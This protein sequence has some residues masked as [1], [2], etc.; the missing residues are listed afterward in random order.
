MKRLS[1]FSLL[2]TIIFS[3]CSCQEPEVK[4]TAIILNSTSLSMTEGDSFK[5]TATVSPDNATDKSVIWSSSNA[6]IADVTD[7]VVTAVKEGAATITVASRDGGARATCEVAVAARIIDVESVTLSQKEA[8]IIVGKTL[9][10]TATV[11][12]ENATDKTVTWTSNNT[13]VATVDNGVVTAVKPGSASITATAGG[14]N[15]SCTVTVKEDYIDVTSVTLSKTSYSLMEGQSFTLYATVKPDDAT[16]KSVTWKSSNEKIATVYDGKVTAVSA[17]KATITA[18]AG[19]V[20]ATCEVQVTAKVAVESI[21]LD[22]KKITIYVGE[23]QAL[24]ATVLPENATDKTISW[25]S[26]DDDVAIVQNGVVKGIAEGSATITAKAG[27]KSATCA[28]TVKIVELESISLNKTELSLNPDEYEQLVVIFKPENA[29]DKTVTWTSDDE[30]VATVSENGTVTGVKPGLATIT[31]KAGNATAKCQVTVFN[32]NY[33]TIT[34]ESKNTG[35]ISI[36]PSG[37]GYY[38]LTLKYSYNGG[39]TWSELNNIKDKATIPMPANSKVSLYAETLTYG[40]R[41]GSASSSTLGFWTISA[42]VPHSLSGELMSLCGYSEALTYDY[43]FYRLFRG[44]KN[45]INAQSL[46]LSESDLTEHCYEDMFSGCTSLE[47]APDV[48]VIKV[49]ASSCKNMFENCTALKETPSLTATSLEG[50]N[51]CYYEMFKGCK[52][53]TKAKKLPATTLSPMCYQSMFQNCTSLKE[54]PEL[55]AQILATYCYRSMFA[56]CTSLTKA[57]ALPAKALAS[58]CY[59]SMFEGCTS[60]ETAPA[61]PAT[62]LASGCYMSMFKDCT[63]LVKAP[64]LPAQNLVNSCYYAMFFDCKA[65]QE[66]PVL[67]ATKLVKNCYNSMFWGCIAL[68]KAPD[69][70]AEKL[71]ANCYE[72]MFYNCRVLSDVTCLAKDISAEDCTKDWLFYVAEKGTFTK[73]AEME[74]WPNG[75]SGVPLGWTLQDLPEEE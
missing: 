1:I 53:L 70:T 10:L 26:S 9:T 51:M 24:T 73:A 2:L 58:M 56:G 18:T 34:N 30:K 32:N 43:Q 12:P 7:G 67:P 47:K 3:I 41:S 8:E 54:A 65:L 5:L 27:G 31:A 52:A 62:V 13:A 25:E 6:S 44:D 48:K 57:P 21:T 22:V 39:K 72:S 46:K 66:A 20:S 28:V 74:S 40:R 69:L 23:K 15:A 61:L 45:L 29:T 64:E 50:A 49:A 60:L 75:P 37:L 19:K 17:G 11:L 35:E 16:D 38:A 63:S 14:K 59:Q 68:A 55:P 4:V 71:A 36:K 33:L 42:D